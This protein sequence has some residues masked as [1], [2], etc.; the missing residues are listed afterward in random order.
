MF[1]YY[2]QAILIMKKKYKNPFF[3]IFSDFSKKEIE[4]FP[5][6]KHLNKKNYFLVKH[7][8][9]SKG[10]LD[11]WLMTKCDHFIIAH[12]SFSW[13]G[14]YLAQ[15]KKKK[16]IGPA[17]KRWKDVKDHGWWHKEIMPKNWKQV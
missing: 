15:N 2:S 17:F 4:S 7:N 3:F 12:S 1:D 8:P 5:F 11:L 16:I 6:M 13:W 9:E 10:H 14:A